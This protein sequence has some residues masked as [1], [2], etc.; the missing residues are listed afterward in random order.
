MGTFQTYQAVGNKEDLLPLIV[1]IT[2][3]KT[4]MLS[5]FAKVKAKGTLHEWLQDSLEAAGTNV[6][7]E[8]SDA[9]A[10]TVIPRVR[11]NNYCQINR[12]TYQISDT[13]EAVDKAGIESEND[14]QR[15]K[16]LKEVARDME[17][18]L[19]NGTGNAGASGTAR[20]IKGVL[21][22]ITENVETGTGTG[23]E[24][25]TEDMYN[26][27]LQTIYDGGGDPDTTYV[28]GFQK[29]KISGFSGN[30]T[31][32]IDAKEKKA[33]NSIGIYESDFGIQRIFLSR[34][35]SADTVVALERDK[36]RIAMLRSVKSTPL[37]K[38]GSSTKTMIEAEWTLEALHQAASGKITQLNTA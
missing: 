22:F 27:L 25:L 2:P 5:A 14:Y 18:S 6:V 15:E 16:K 13:Q 35:M 23:N 9:V 33:I 17:Y 26:D 10:G 28:N 3:T 1:N 32:N 19:V 8:G 11:V 21:A 37:A 30:A 36:W 38:V 31:K 29:R 7:V 12:K 24:T 20:E 4:P 34:F